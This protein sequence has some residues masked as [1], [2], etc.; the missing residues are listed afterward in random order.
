MMGGE[1]SKP[2]SDPAEESREERPCR[3]RM[4]L[5]MVASWYSWDHLCWGEKQEPSFP[6]RCHEAAL[7]RLFSPQEM[8]ETL[9]PHALKFLE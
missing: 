2:L 5:S 8:H 6:L 7:Q 1:Q 3:K 9:V 4:I